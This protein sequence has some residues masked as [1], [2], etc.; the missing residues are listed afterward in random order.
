MKF[1]VLNSGSRGNCYILTASNGQKLIIEAGVKIEKINQALNFEFGSVVGCLVS[2]SHKDHALSVGDLLQQGIKVFANSHVHE[3]T[4]TKFGFNFN[5]IEEMKRFEV[6]E[7]SV[8]SIPMKH[9]V[10]TLG[11]LINHSESGLI[12]FATDTYFVNFDFRE[13]DLKHLI[14]EANYTEEKLSIDDYVSERV[15]R[16]HLS[17]ESLLKI[18]ETRIEKTSVE[19]CLLIHLSDSRSDE[20][21]F[22]RKVDEAFFGFANVSA[23]VP[24]LNIKLEKSIF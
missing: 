11:F 14:I 4:K 7:F 24:G 3:T 22:I 10:P 15:R 16:S 5:T 17:I 12:L 13:L 9:D 8:F 18:I 19:N 1:E 6:G 23:A 2:H 21:E 20:K